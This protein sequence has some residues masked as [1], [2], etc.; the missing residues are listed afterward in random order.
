[1]ETQKRVPE[2]I[3]GVDWFVFASLTLLLGALFHA[4]AGVVTIIKDALRSA[5]DV[6]HVPRPV[7]A[8]APAEL[9]VAHGSWALLTGLTLALGAF[10]HIGR[11]VADLFRGTT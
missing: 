4:I 8:G 6:P 7:R 3:G 1:M 10:F 2:Q 9:Q 5:P 11:A